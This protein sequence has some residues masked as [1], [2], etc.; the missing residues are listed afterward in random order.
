MDFYTIGAAPPLFAPPL[1]ITLRYFDDLGPL[2][3]YRY[4][5]VTPNWQQVPTTT[6]NT[7]QY[8]LTVDASALSVYVVLMGVH[9]GLEIGPPTAA[10]EGYPGSSVGYTLRVTNTGD[11]TDTID[12]AAAGLWTPSLSTLV[13]LSL[14]P[15][16]SEILTLT[17]DIPFAASSGMSDTAVITATSTISP[18]LS[19]TDRMTK[20]ALIHRTHMPVILKD[21]GP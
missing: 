11:Y 3:V 18:A 2:A 21:W 9:P 4:D 14:G 6:Q 17:V 16:L 1:Q 10:G 12:L 20:T 13:V 15:N 5:G 8:T 19:R 7:A